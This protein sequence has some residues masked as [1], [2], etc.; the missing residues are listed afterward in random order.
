VDTTAIRSFNGGIRQNSGNSD[1]S[2]EQIAA[3]VEEFKRL[4][5]GRVQTLS[6]I[7]FSYWRKAMEDVLAHSQGRLYERY[8]ADLLT[9]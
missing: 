4:I 6:L 1:H 2:R 8:E 7:N 5:E 9:R 3:E